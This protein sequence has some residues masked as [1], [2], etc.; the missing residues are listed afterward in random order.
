VESDALVGSERGVTGTPNFF[1]NGRKLAGAQPIEALIAVVD[2]LKVPSEE[3]RVLLDVEVHDEFIGL[4]EGVPTEVT[5]KGPHGKFTMDAFEASIENGKAVSRPGAVTTQNLTWYEASDACKAAGKRLCTE[6][7]WLSACTGRIAKDRDGDGVFSDDISGNRHPYGTWPQ[8]SYCAAYRKRDDTSPLITGNHPKCVTPQGVYDL[9][10]LTKE[11]VGVQAHK[12][13]A[14]GGS[15]ASRESARCGYFKDN[16]VPSQ[17]E[18]TTGFRC[19]KGELP[20]ALTADIHP[21]GKVGDKVMDWSLP[22]EG[23]G[24]LSAKDLAGKPV[25]MTF[26]ATWCGPCR[27]ELPALAALFEQYKAQGLQVVG[28]NVDENPMKLKK[29]LRENPLP[30]PVVLDPDSK[31]KNQFD[32]ESVPATYWIQRDGTIRQ[33]TVGYD[34]KKKKKLEESAANL[35]Q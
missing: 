26:W 4:V 16:M 34:E 24:T 27:K 23:G 14:K 30:F 12:A 2:T 11:W 10:G 29:Y 20:P 5:L 3:G 33:K 9:E 22:K 18:E 19:C 35:L 17:G 28:V 6:E 1:V 8:A 32:A 31:L 25:I 7:E 13:G 21:G 15:F